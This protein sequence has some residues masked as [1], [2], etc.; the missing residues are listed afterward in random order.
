MN[1]EIIF[2]EFAKYAESDDEYYTWGKHGAIEDVLAWFNIPSEKF[3]GA[4]SHVHANN[5]EKLH[6]FMITKATDDQLKLIANVIR[7]KVKIPIVDC[8]DNAAGKVF[9]SMPMNEQKCDCIAMIRGGICNALKNTGNNPYFLDRDS[10]SENIYNVMLEHI[11]SC[12]FLVADLTT[13]NNGV[14][15]EAGYAKALGKTVIFTCKNSDF[16]NIHF[17]IKQIQ[18]ISWSDEAEL[19]NKLAEQICGLNLAICD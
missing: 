19:A 5:L 7:K 3:V 8:T 12:K 14:Y 18:T 16:A 2:N 13:Q 11:H 9:V 4:S 6:D 17:D 1:A 15:Y 10:H